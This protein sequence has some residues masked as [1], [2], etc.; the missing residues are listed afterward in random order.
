MNS[1]NF[2]LENPIMVALDV[3]SAERCLELARALAG[4]VGSFKIGPRLSVRYGASLVK[5]LA[6]TAPV[7]LDNKYLDIPSTMEGAVR[8]SFD[9]GAT[10]CTIHT[11]SGGEA[12]SK[13]A[14][15]E[16]ELSARRPFKLLAVT[17]LTSFS[18]ETLPPTMREFA[19]GRQVSELADLA[20]ASGITG[21]VCSPQEL[22]ELRSRHPRAFLVSP[23]VRLP[24]DAIG[25]QK[26]VETPEAA[27]RAGASAIVVGRPIIEAADPVA[28]AERILASAKVGRI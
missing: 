18:E 19:L 16:K 4:K 12:M 11:W 24:T 3:D 2:E 13:L 21:L 25:D 6:E 22:S 17:V 1:E 10:F 8:A 7:F 9:A 27:M 14:K 23:G 15:I 28:A 20:L 26:R 5:S